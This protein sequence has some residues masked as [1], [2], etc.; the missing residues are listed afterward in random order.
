[1]KYNERIFSWSDQ[2][3]LAKHARFLAERGCRVVISNADHPSI[4]ELYEGFDCTVINRP[5]V[6]AAS[7]AHRRTITECIFVLGE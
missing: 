6:I 5:S 3:R 2:Q 1:M 7:S 4:H